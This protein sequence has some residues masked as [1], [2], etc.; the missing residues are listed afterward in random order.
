MAGIKDVAKRARVG[1]GTVSRML[2]D[3][4]Y[5]AEGTR[6]KIEIAMK[7]LNY[8]PNELARNL[9]HK[10]TGIIAVLVPNVSNPFFSEFVDHVEAELYETGFKMMLC[11]AAKAC[12]AEREYLD[13]LNRHIVDGVITGVHSLDVEEYKKIHKPIVAL[14]RYLGEHIPV[15]AVDHKEG[16]R[17]AA[18][19]LID[20]GCRKILHVKGATA[21]KSPY[22]DRHYE[23]ERVMKKNQVE[24]YSYELEWN[25]FDSEYY[26]EVVAD[27]FSKEIDFDGVFAVDELAIECMNEAIR[28]HFKVPRDVKFVAYDGTFITEMVEPKMTAVVQPIASLAKESVR[29]LNE[30]IGGREYKNKRVVLGVQI[31]K[32]NTTIS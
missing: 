6:E 1:V 9:Y 19:T 13:M 32:G 14:D 24:T 25:R 16:G 10:R 26:R 15:V 30:L 12:S 31:R 17:L 23:F 20:C 3:S 22:H 8:T 5:V 27:V 18:E 7:E 21:V 29:L 28:R 11:N 2:N 4:G